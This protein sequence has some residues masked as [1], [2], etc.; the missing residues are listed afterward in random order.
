PDGKALKSMQMTAMQFRI[1]ALAC[2]GKFFEGMVVFMT[3]VALPLISIQ[4][5][6]NAAERGFVTAA[7]LA[8]ILA[9][10]TALGGL[11]DRNGRKRMVIEEIL[12]FAVFLGGLTFHPNFIRL[13]ICL[14]GA[15]IALGCDYPTPPM[16]S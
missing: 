6:L 13:F 3:G 15:G 9:G 2:A 10:A 4:F 14:F 11:A 1:G 7:S 8:G 12:S 5:H 16:V